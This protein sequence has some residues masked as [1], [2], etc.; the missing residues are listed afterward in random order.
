MTTHKTQFGTD[1]SIEILRDTDADTATVFVIAPIYKNKRWPLHH[2][3]VSSQ[4][5]DS[6][7]LNDRDFIRVMTAAFKD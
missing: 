2:Q 1:V 6:Q 4:F 3:Y 7:I 5:T